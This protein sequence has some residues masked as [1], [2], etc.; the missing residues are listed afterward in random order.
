MKRQC[1]SVPISIFIPCIFKKN[2]L[3][4]KNESSFFMFKEV[5]HSNH[6]DRSFKCNTLNT[7]NDVAL[8]FHYDALTSKGI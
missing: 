3:C 6:S 8:I 1:V 4:E 5:V 7:E 2:T